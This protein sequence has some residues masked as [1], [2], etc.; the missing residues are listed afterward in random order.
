MNLWFVLLYACVWPVFRIIIPVKSVNRHNIPEGAALYCPNH[1]RLTDPLC[2][3]FAL[4]HPRQIHAMAKEELMNIPLLGG[5][6]KR[7]GIFGVKRGKADIGA[8]KKA[9]RCLKDGERLMMFPEGTR[10]QDGEMRDAKTGCAMV[11]VR[12]GVPIVPVFI[13]AKKK[14]FRFTK[15]VFGEPY[16]PQVAGT[17]ANAEDYRIIADDLLERIRALEVQSL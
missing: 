9:M 4:G 6:L 1:T 12:T 10:H 8:I 7:A 17:K 15:V 14:L 5:L 16:Y 2:L 13:P 11:A 3:A